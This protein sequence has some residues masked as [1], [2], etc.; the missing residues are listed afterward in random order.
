MEEKAIVDAL[1]AG[2]QNKSDIN[3][4]NAVLGRMKK[5]LMERILDAE[6]SVHLGYEKHEAAGRGSGN[7]RNGKTTKRVIMDD[8]PVDVEIPRDRAGTFEPQLIPRHQRRLAGF[9][10]KVLSLYT[11]GM[12]VREIQGHLEELY[13]TQ[14]SPELISRVTDA[15]MEEVEEWKKRPLEALYAIVALDCLMVKSRHE[16]QVKT[17]AVY[18]ALGTTLA[19]QKEVLG[20]WMDDTEGAKFWL[21]VL[22]GLKNRGVK[23]ILIALVDG[24]KGFPEAIAAAF[25]K[26]VVQGCVVHMIR[27]ATAQVTQSERAEVARDLKDI[28]RAVDEE[29]ASQALDA[30]GKKWDPKYPIISRSFRNNWAVFIPFLAFPDTIRR[31]LYTTNSIESLNFTLRKS[32]KTR[33]HFP[34]EQAVYKILYLALRNHAKNWTKPPPAW[35]QAMAQFSILYSER[36]QQALGQS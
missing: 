22:N 31:M 20:L 28:Y 23:E 4:V 21:N 34:N 36:I 17:R 35:K 27:H 14:V 24:L 33:G 25:P 3:E 32:I 19:G 18:V 11:R 8:G 1:L 5:A 29:A 30:F 13:G 9:D 7:S 16:G 15:V 2:V 26:T 12:S 6:L 10:E